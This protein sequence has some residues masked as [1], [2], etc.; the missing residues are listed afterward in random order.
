MKMPITIMI[1]MGRVV[2]ECAAA[3]IIIPKMLV[4]PIDVQSR[5]F[6]MIRILTRM[7]QVI[8]PIAMTRRTVMMRRIMINMLAFWKLTHSLKNYRDNDNNDAD[9]K[10]DNGHDSD[11]AID[12]D[13]NV[14]DGS[15][16]IYTVA[17]ALQ[18]TTLR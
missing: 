2:V 10:D 7:N 15:A 3:V 13:A 18:T 11:G 6:I 16:F 17:R 1:M 8:V 14:Q 12:V 5:I 4:R 9:D